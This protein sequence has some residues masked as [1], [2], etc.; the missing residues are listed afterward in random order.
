[1]N[2]TILRTQKNQNG[3]APIIIKIQEGFYNVF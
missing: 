1:M 2:K 3:G